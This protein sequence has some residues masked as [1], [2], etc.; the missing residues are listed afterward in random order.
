MMPDLDYDPQLDAEEA[1][2][3]AEL[4]WLRTYDDTST[5]GGV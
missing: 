1:A 3:R 5:V 2:R 4:A